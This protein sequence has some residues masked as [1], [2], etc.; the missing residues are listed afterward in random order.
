MG[1]QSETAGD[2]LGATADARAMPAANSDHLALAMNI[3]VPM[4]A[5]R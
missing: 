1:D 3:D 4:V 2:A 5:L